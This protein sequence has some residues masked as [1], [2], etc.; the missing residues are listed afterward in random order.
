MAVAPRLAELNDYVLVGIPAAADGSNKRVDPAAK[1]APAGSCA[2]LDDVTAAVISQFDVVICVGNVGRKAAERIDALCRANPRPSLAHEANENVR[3]QT[4]VFIESSVRGLAG[5]IFCDFGKGHL[6]SDA[7]GQQPHT[8]VVDGVSRDEQ[9]VVFVDASKSG[10]VE[11]GEYIKFRDVTGMKELEGIKA[12]KVVKVDPGSSTLTIDVDTREF[13][14]FQQGNASAVVVKV[15][16]AADFPSLA[17]SRKKPIPG[18]DGPGG[19]MWHWF[20]FS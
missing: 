8:V 2:S 11:Q 4:T 3:N 15:P 10:R 19:G 18:D 17:D 6:I 1:E 20:D 9:A 12:C 14:D 13:G 16:F 7:D 5:R